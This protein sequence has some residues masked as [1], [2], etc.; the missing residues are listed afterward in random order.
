MSQK[1]CIDKISLPTD[2][3]KSA[4]FCFALKCFFGM[5]D[6]APNPVRRTNKGAT[7]FALNYKIILFLNY[8]C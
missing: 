1:L 2:K 3:I 6:F 7:H 4:H 8:V 5:V